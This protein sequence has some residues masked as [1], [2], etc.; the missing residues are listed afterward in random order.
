MSLIKELE[1]EENSFITMAGGGGK[2]TGM[3]LLAKLLGNS[4][5]TS[6][7]KLYKPPIV[8]GIVPVQWDSDRIQQF[9]NESYTIKPKSTNGTTIDT[10]PLVY[11]R[12]EGDKYMGISTEDAE[13]LKEKSSFKHILCEGDGARM[14][15]L[16]VW[17]EGEPV[18]PPSTTH[19]IINIGAKVFGKSWGENW[20]H[21]SHLLPLDGQIIG[22][23]TLVQMAKHGVFDLD[24]PKASKLFIVIN[25]WDAIEEQFKGQKEQFEKS[26]KGIIPSLTKV[27]FVSYEKNMIY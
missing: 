6:T 21:R 25:Q 14:K 7:T 1:I 16:K 10:I 22:L 8:E 24:I 27:L 23:E 19:I 4:L 13:L 2:T 5:I 18:I 17:K 20:V 15:P 12:K 3:F 11:S 26:L 9:I